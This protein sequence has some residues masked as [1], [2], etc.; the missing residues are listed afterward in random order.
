MSAPAPV[1]ADLAAW[2]A[3]R[4]QR[5]VHSLQRRFPGWLI[6]ADGGLPCSLAVFAARRPGLEIV[7]S[8]AAALET[9]LLRWERA[10]G[11]PDLRPV[12]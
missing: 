9:E 5:R 2:Q 10:P 12:P 11:A 7:R 3:G 8:T 4:T 6:S 1:P